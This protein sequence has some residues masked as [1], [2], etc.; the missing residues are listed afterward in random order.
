MRS[1]MTAACASVIAYM[2]IGAQAGPI[3]WNL[4]DVF[5]DDGSEA[6]GSFDFDADIERYSNINIV[7]PFATYR[8]PNPASP[9]NASILIAVI[10][11]SLTDFTGTPVLALSFESP[12]S[13]IGGEINLDT[14][15]IARSEGICPDIQCSGSDPVRSVISGQ[16]SASVPAPSTLLLSCLGLA[17]IGFRSYS[18]CYATGFVR[19]RT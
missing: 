17:I 4:I 12:L 13:H 14:S 9:G 15:A 19:R 6:T 7:T 16:V 10:D 5:F 8:A 1:F 11:E 3:T 2:S 18:G